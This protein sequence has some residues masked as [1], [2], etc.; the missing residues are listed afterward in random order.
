MDI[1][2]K[3]IGTVE[4]DVLE[5]KDIPWGGKV[6]V[7]LVHKELEKGLTG[8]DTFSHAI[9]ITY[10]HLAKFS[11]EKHMVRS[12]RNR[13]DMPKIGIFSQRT[14]D[15]PN[16]IGITTVEILKVEGNKVFVQGLDV[17]NGT[18][19]LDIKPYYP[20]FDKREGETPEWVDRLMVDYF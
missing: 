20:A 11:G 19:V 16:P 8:L 15:H 10:L 5:K 2:M 6:S 3:A 1:E 9:I 18:P 14:K 4:N 13:E 7:I 12:P 17:M